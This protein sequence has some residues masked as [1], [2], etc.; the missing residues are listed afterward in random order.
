M[1]VGGRDEIANLVGVAGLGGGVSSTSEITDG[2]YFP[3]FLL[4]NTNLGE[5]AA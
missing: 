1:E 3:N 4:L 5:G 2:R